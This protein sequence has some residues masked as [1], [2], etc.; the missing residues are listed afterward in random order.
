M[1]HAKDGTKV[2]DNL[3]AVNSLAYRICPT[4]RYATHA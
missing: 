4:E 1:I 3:K 2:L